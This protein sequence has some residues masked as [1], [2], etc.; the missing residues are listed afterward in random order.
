MWNDGTL[1]E[2]KWY[3]FGLFKTL[4]WLPVALRINPKL[5]PSPA[6]PIP[7]SVS[8][9]ITL[10]PFPLVQPH[11]LPWVLQTCSSHLCWLGMLDTTAFSTV[12]W[13]VPHVRS[14]LSC[15]LLTG[16]FTNAQ[17]L[18]HIL[19]LLSSI[20]HNIMRNY[21]VY[22]RTCLPTL[23]GLWALCPSCFHAVFPAV[24][25]IVVQ[26]SSVQF[27]RSVVSNSLRPR[28]LQHA[29]PPCPTSAPRVYPNSCSSWW[30][31]PAISSSVVPFSSCP[32]SLPASEPFPVSQLFAWGG[33]S[34]GVS[35]LASVLPMNTQDWSPSEWSAWISLQ[36]KG[37]SRVF[38]NTTVQKHQFFGAQLSS[39]FSSHIHTRLLEK[40]YHSVD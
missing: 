17:S 14:Q 4:Q 20:A 26:F 15:R 1:V 18:Y 13:L 32:Q 36:S 2:L 27:S 21:L 39:Q 30:W 19:C 22:L 31:H 10:P 12:S 16:T 8:S 29:R 23:S 24:W 11:C 6:R 5:L 28:E 25:H 38:S 3:R 33:Q 40:D 34:I 7:D 37:L 9:P 35:A